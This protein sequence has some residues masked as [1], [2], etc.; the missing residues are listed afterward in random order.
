[1]LNGAVTLG[2][3]DGANVEIHELV[4]DENIYVF[5][6]KSETVIAHYEKSDYVA[7]DL[8]KKSSAIE[9]KP[10]FAIFTSII[11]FHFSSSL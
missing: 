7:K 4:G 5:G 10:A 3:S 1:M 2:T 8:Y 6:E 11:R 9:K